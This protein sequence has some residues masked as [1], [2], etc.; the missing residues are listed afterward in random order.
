MKKKIRAAGSI[1]RSST[2]TAAEF[3]QLRKSVGLTQTELGSVFGYGSA[4][5]Q[6][7]VSEYENGR[8]PIPASRAIHLQMLVDERFGK[9]RRSA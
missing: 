7:V 9:K 2:M 5:G 4:A 1:R 3:R 8:R 6:V